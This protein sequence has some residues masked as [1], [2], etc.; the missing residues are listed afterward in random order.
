MVPGLAGRHRLMPAAYMPLPTGI[1]V[2]IDALAV[3]GG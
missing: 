2:E 1:L 3:L